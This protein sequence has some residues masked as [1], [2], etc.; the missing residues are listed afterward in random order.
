MIQIATI[1]RDE[2]SN[3]GDLGKLSF[4]GVYFCETLQP[5]V[6]DEAQGRFHLPAND[7]SQ[8]FYL[9]TRYDS[10]KH[11]E[12]FIIHRPET[13]VSVDGHSYLEF[14][15][16]NDIE[17]TLGCTILGET[18][19]KLKGERAVLNSGNTFKKFQ[20]ITADVNVFKLVVID[21]YSA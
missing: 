5:D 11:G 6:L 20:Q 12:T 2:E 21:N 14:H 19:G 7:T 9:C 17:D 15:A 13:P 18:R 10:P 3:Q 16:G 8:P 1:I 4:D